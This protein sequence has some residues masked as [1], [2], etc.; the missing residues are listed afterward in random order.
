MS[1]N[2]KQRQMKTWRKYLQYKA[3]NIFLQNI[4][5]WN[6][7]WYK[8]IKH[9]V[10]NFQIPFALWYPNANILPCWLYHILLLSPLSLCFP[11]LLSLFL[12]QSSETWQTLNHFTPKQ[13][14]VY[15]LKTK[16]S[17]PQPQFSYQN[18][19]INI[20]SLI[21][22][23]IQFSPI[24]SV[25]NSRFFFLLQDHMLSITLTIFKFGTVP[26]GDKHLIYP[27]SSIEN[28]VSSEPRSVSGKPG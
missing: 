22:R 13:Y 27:N 23:P 24:I 25:A 16:I 9:G 15:F 10:K 18:K 8:V 1:H 2:I 7:Y 14:S 4:L 3:D 17:L 6:H 19:E 12:P 26:Q 5:C 20:D 11:L 28:P 21:C